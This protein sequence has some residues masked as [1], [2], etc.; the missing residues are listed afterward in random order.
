LVGGFFVYDPLPYKKHTNFNMNSPI[1]ISFQGDMLERR[2][3]AEGICRLI[4]RVKG[5]VIAVDGEWG[6]GKTWFGENLKKLIDDDGEYA[7]VW[8]DAFEAD[9]DD[10]PALTLIA[11]ISAQ[12]PLDDRVEFIEKVAPYVLKAIPAVAK[13][14]VKVVGNYFGADKDI[15]DG[16]SEAING[17]GESYVKKKIEELAEKRKALAHLKSIVEAYV[18][19]QV[20][21]KIII[22]VDEID[23]CSPGYSIKLLERLKHLFDIDGVF[24]IL[25]WNRAQIKNTVEAFYGAGTNGQMFLDKFIDYPLSLSISNARRSTPPMERLLMSL[26]EELPQDVR[27]RFQEN[28]E[29]LKAVTMLLGLN[30]RET[31]RIST[32]WVMSSKRSFVALENWLLA[33]KVKYPQVYKGIR[34]GDAKCH[35]F[36]CELIKKMANDNSASKV[37]TVFL[38]YHDCHARENFDIVDDDLNRFFTSYGVSIRDS[39]GVAIRHIEDT[40]D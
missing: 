33:L 17:A 26:T 19:K 39:L 32:W 9:W 23:R 35:D 36:C 40:F 31:M 12:M 6:V 25:L 21:G 37:A 29:W 13:A 30:A 8:L 20:S 5:G 27:Y 18:K 1:S 22:F 38:K 28:I 24:F 11:E 34:E 4:S 2:Q 3:F 10:D 7:T 15:V 16:V 14:G